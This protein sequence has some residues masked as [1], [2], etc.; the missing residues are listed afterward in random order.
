MIHDATL[1]SP[2][3][4]PFPEEREA[5]R[6]V[7]KTLAAVRGAVGTSIRKSEDVHWADDLSTLS[8][9]A[10]QLLFQTLGEGE[11]RI[12]L[13]NGAAW[14]EET[15][16]PGLWKMTIGPQTSLV[17][18]RIPRSVEQAVAA[19]ASGLPE[20]RRTAGGLF[21][22]EAVLTELRELL[23]RT[24][25]TTIPD[26]AAPQLDLLHQPLSPAD[27][28]QVLSAVGT[29]KTTILITGFARTH[30]DS[31]RIKGLWRTRI[32]NHA[33]KPLMDSLTV[34]LIPPEVPCGREDWPESLKKLKNLIAWLEDDLRHRESK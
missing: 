17:A 27:L 11:V 28:N 26:T 21:A 1:N 19:G 34:A 14:A 8:S 6:R 9:G 24:D 3:E 18:A 20:P 12:A 29:G 7:L 4:F 25:L 22:A 10:K 16:V 5:A 30:I 15:A 13:F 23:A 31:T 33:G 32:F 2:L